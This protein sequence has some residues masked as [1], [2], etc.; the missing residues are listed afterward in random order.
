MVLGITAR[1]TTERP[2][3][4]TRDTIVGLC[5]LETARIAPRAHGPIGRRSDADSD[6]SNSVKLDISRAFW[7]YRQRMGCEKLHSP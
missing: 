7:L 3:K 6:L 5:E 4:A 1:G 2:L